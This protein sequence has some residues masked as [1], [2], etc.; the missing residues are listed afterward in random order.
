MIRIGKYEIGFAPFTMA[1]IFVGLSII[2]VLT[3]LNQASP[4]Y[5]MPLYSL[6]IINESFALLATLVYGIILHFIQ[7]CIRWFKSH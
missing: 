3:A 6:I 2:A 5:P 4:E 1:V 7:T